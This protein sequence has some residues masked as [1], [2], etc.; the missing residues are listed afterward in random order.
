M[1]LRGGRC[2]EHRQGSGAKHCWEKTDLLR[3]WDRSVWVEAVASAD[4]LF[5]STVGQVVRAD[6]IEDNADTEDPDAG[7]PGEPFLATNDLE[8][9]EE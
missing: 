8:E 9:A 7:H 5:N 1:A 2:D 6:R 3:A 4:D